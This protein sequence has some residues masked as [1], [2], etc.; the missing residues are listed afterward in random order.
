MNPWPERILQWRLQQETKVLTQTGFLSMNRK[1]KNKTSCYKTVP[2]K[3]VIF[4]VGKNVITDTWN[5]NVEGVNKHD[6]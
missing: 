4:A 2:Q 1:N 6:K 3:N 5:V